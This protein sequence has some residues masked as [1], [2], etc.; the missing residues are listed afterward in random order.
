M[1]NKRR[2]FSSYEELLKSYYGVGHGKHRKHSKELVVSKSFDN[3]ETL[4]Q[5]N[6]SGS[7]EEY[8][9]QSSITDIPYEEYVVSAPSFSS[10]N[11]AP[12]SPYTSSQSSLPV[13]DN[14]ID[15]FKF[16]PD[17]T[18]SDTPV[19]N[20][21]EPEERNYRPSMQAST[22]AEYAEPIDETSKATATEDDFMKDM[23]DILSGKR[24]YNPFTRQTEEK[25]SMQSTGA[26]GPVSQKPQG[27]PLPEKNEHE[28]FDR[29]AQSMEYANAYDL[30]SINLDKRFS[31]FDKMYEIEKTVVPKKP[32]SRSASVAAQKEPA[33]GNEEFIRDLD[34]IIKGDQKAADNAPQASAVKAEATPVNE[35]ESPKS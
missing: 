21:R 19:Y 34:A 16:I 15:L 26:S 18:S 28:I 20:T 17:S 9:V 30:G 35:T 24:M 25:S 4:M 7:C 14:D 27:K 11:V 29:I 32:V 13:N 33:A 31:D 2:D 10:P 23:E 22:E 8:V 1:K 12:V 6:C 3:G 5:K